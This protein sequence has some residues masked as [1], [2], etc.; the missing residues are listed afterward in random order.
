MRRHLFAASL[1]AAFLLGLAP[2]ASAQAPVQTVPFP[3]FG[4]GGGISIPAGGVAKDRAP[5]F[6]LVGLAEFRTPSEPL[7]IRAEALYQYFGAKQN[8]V[9]VESSNNFAA[10]INVVYHAPRSQVR[11]YVIG[12]MGLYH[13]SDHG[14]NAGVNGGVG[15]TI[16]LTGM[17]AYA[18][19]RLHAALTQGPSFVTLPITFGITF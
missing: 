14:N 16:P 18:E 8:S 3:I 2:G 17:G 9:G 10:L 11:P 19:V 4:V 13:I 12:G 5:G 6:N 1:T 15:V 7:G